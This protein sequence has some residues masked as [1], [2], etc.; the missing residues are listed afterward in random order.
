MSPDH[1]R[2]L[3]ELVARNRLEPRAEPPTSER[4]KVWQHAHP[5]L[6]AAPPLPSLCQCRRRPNRFAATVT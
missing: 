2:P 1:I 3:P 5:R 6:N 4:G